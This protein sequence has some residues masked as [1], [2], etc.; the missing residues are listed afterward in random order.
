[1]HRVGAAPGRRRRRSSQRIAAE[2][3]AAAPGRGVHPP[4]RRRRAGRP[5]HRPAS[6]RRFDD[7][8]AAL[9]AGLDGVAVHAANSAGALAHPAARRSFVR[10][11]IAAVRHLAR[12]RR[13][14]RSPPTCARCCRCKARVSFVK[15]LAAGRAAVVRAAPHASPPTPTS[16]RCRSAT[17]TACAAGCR[18]TATV[19]IGGRRRPIVGTITMDQLMV[20]CGDDPVRPRRR[21]RA[22]RPPGR[23][24]DHAPRSGPTRSARSATRSC[25]AS[26]P[27]VPRRYVGRAAGARNIVGVMSPTPLH[28][29]RRRRSTAPT[30]SPPRSP[31][32]AGAGDVILLA[33]EMGAGKTAF[34][35]GFGR[36]LGVTEPIT[37]PTFTLVHSYDTGGVDAAPRRPLP[38]RPARRGRRPG[39]RRAGRVST[40]SCSSSGATSSSRRSAST[41]RAPRARR[42]RRS[43][44]G[45]STISA[46]GRDVG[47][48]AGPPLVDGRRPTG[49]SVSR[50]C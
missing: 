19:L 2:R 29:A 8:L 6:S 4:R 13:R 25:A 28:A 43:T 46:V 47:A 37:S 11:G 39:A 3:A 31:G 27:R 26:A 5:V 18:R 32:S 45:A 35:Q 15:R 10:A 33:G 40:A 34:A 21:G 41:S 16:R 36:A 7:V 38:A 17:P 14:R 30:P 44:P 12:A 9:P 22:D 48:G 24:A 50:R 42:R 23:R 1:M 49:R 20:D